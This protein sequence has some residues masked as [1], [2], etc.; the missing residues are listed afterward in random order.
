MKGLAH[1]SLG[2][3]ERAGASSGLLFAVLTLAVGAVCPL[4][5]ASSPETAAS[6]QAAPAREEPSTRAAQRRQQRQAKLEQI[7]PPIR[8]KIQLALA[9][10]EERGRQRLENFN[11]KRFFPKFGGLSTG[12]GFAFGTR[13]WNPRLRGGGWDLQAS[14]A[15]SLQGYQLVDFQLGQVNQPERSLTAYADFRYRDFPQEDFF[16]LGTD[17]RESDRTDYRIEDAFLGATLRYRKD[18]FQTELRSGFLMVDIDRGTDERFPDAQDLFDDQEAPGLEQQPDFFLVGATLLLDSRDQPGNPHEGGAIRFTVGRFDD[19]D[20]DEF[21]FTRVATD[22]FYYLPLWSSGRTFAFRFTTSLDIDD[23]GSRVPFYFQR[24]LG[25]SEMLRGFREFRFR[26]RN[27]VF[28]STE[29]RWEAIPALEFALF[30]D[31]G[32]V[33]PRRSDFNLDGL[34]TSFGLGIRVKTRS[35][36][37]LRIDMAHS[38]EGNRIY[39]KFGPAF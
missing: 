30:Y 28:L 11:F 26:D 29:Y 20:G 12:S 2:R 8:P 9:W 10:F 5:A 1:G 31:A 4:G 23:R 6:P 16:G 21:D 17:S 39:F 22:V 3:G 33:F 19:L 27:L 35:S 34:Q 15:T 7:E 36:V 24:T 37:V 14:A 13:Y 25:G 38:R 18:W 32:K